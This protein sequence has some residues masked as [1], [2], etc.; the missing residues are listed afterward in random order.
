MTVQ[1]RHTIRS[2][3]IMLRSA[4]I[5]TPEKTPAL[6]SLQQQHLSSLVRALQEIK[7]AR[8]NPGREIGK[9]RKSEYWKK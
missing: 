6:D 3:T 4:N 9:Y 7:V 8:N 5:N 1:H 2:V